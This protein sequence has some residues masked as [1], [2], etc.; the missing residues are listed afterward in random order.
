MKTAL[1]IAG[2]DSGG[3]AGIQADLKTFSA[4]GVFGMSVIT[5]V[6]AQNTVEVRS[7]QHIDINVIRD[8]MEA[9]LDD[10]GADAIKIGMLGSAKI[11]KAVAE[12][13]TIY[14]PKHIILDPVMIS[15]SGHHLLE[16]DAVSE[17]KNK[18]LPL[19]SLVTPNLPEAEELTGC[20][21]KTKQDVYSASEAIH[22]LGAQAVLIKGGHFAGNSDD[23]FYD[24]ET[25]TW[26]K[27]ERIQTSNTHGTGCTLSAAIAAN[28]AK[29]LTMSE[30]IK[31]AKAYV[32]R[33]IQNSL[34]IGK[35]HGPLN[36]FHNFEKINH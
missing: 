12:V 36:H 22:Q 1:T 13:L 16:T 2:S 3:G 27:G 35:G 14:N 24:G 9:V 32:T 18:L 26:L 15:K 11:A 4:H 33:A 31:T 19:S 29:G 6:T 28:L 34:S 20:K 21:I 5:S 10:I 17:L 30:A 25:F 7:V 23:L 8:Q